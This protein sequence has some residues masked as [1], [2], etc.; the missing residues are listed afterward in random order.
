MKRPILTVEVRFEQDVVLTRQRARQLAALLGFDAL[1]QTRVATAV[2][3]VARFI[4]QQA[5]G[6]KVEFQVEDGEPARLVIRISDREPG[7][8]DLAALRDPESRAAEREVGILAAR[9]LV[10]QF[11][12]TTAPG[13]GTTVQLGKSFSR[14]MAAVTPAALARVAA[15]LARQQPQNPVEEIQQQNQELL[16]TLTAL[17]ARPGGGGK[18]ECGTGPGGPAQGRVPGDAGPRA[19]QPARP[20]AH[21]L[22][23][24]SRRGSE[25]ATLDRSCAVMERQVRHLT[26]LIDD[27]L[28]VSRPPRGHP[29]GA[30]SSCSPSGS[31]WPRWCG[32]PSTITAR[33]SRRP[34]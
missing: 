34:R 7:I 4:F 3:E 2:S 5:G 13:A 27:L 10:D 29:P 15:E 21:A 12:V 24:L 20:I 1:D 26:R 32:R 28:D 23:L 19:A 6:G 25:A 22:Y 33:R 16:Q 30:R 14:R 18:P 9:R 31:I 17:R 11:E 8:A